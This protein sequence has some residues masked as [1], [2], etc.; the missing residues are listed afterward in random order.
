MRSRTLRRHDLNNL[1]R[2]SE[3]VHRLGHSREFLP[4]RACMVPILTEFPYCQAGQ[5]AMHDAS[6]IP[7]RQR[8]SGHTEM[9]QIFGDDCREMVRGVGEPAA[10]RSSGRPTDENGIDDGGRPPVDVNRPSHFRGA[11]KRGGTHQ[12][13]IQ[14]RHTDGAIGFHLVM[15][16]SE[17]ERSARAR[18][19]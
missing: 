18:R 11:G 1:V 16:V 15:V 2:V 17:C 13:G 14:N 9:I 10:R 5:M 7:V 8:P 4:C 12:A 19:R 6:D 3:S